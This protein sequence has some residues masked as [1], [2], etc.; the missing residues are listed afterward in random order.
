MYVLLKCGFESKASILFFI[1]DVD[2]N[3][4]ID[5]KEMMGLLKQIGCD[6]GLDSVETIYSKMGI[7]SQM[8]YKEFLNF[9]ELVTK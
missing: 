4:T 5:K 9:I 8:T 7:K 3:G 2:H 6:V 1:N